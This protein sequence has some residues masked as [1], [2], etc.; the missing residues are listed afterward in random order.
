MSEVTPLTPA[1][2]RSLRANLSLVFVGSVLFLVSAFALRSHATALLLMREDALPLAADLTSLSQKLSLIQEQIS[3]T[4][5]SQAQTRAS[6][7]E[8]LSTFVLP[9]KPNQARAVAVLDALQF[10]LKQD[11]HL[12]T[13]SS[14]QLGEVAV[15]QT[16]A[17]LH[18]LPIH[19]SFTVDEAGAKSLLLFEELSG[20][21]TV[22]DVLT[23]GQTSA[24]VR[25]CTEGNPANAPAL[26]QFLSLDLL[27]YA[28][29]PD[30]ALQKLLGSV[31]SSSCSDVAHSTIRD[32]KLTEA[33]KLL[34][35]SFGETL[36]ARNLWP[37]PFFVARAVALRAEGDNVEVSMELEVLAK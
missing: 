11:T 22:G 14:V 6:I 7:R 37:M 30:S 35:G 25:A 23:S 19:T 29:S 8:Q 28:R 4:E 16:N 3:L 24:F 9:E 17:S 13:S 5:G 26:E 18:A 34:G 32:S 10:A 20:A 15:S 33:A 21:L 12:F 27:L 31:S 1:K 2:P 36:R